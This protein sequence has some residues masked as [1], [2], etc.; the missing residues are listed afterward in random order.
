MM[1]KLVVKGLKSFNDKGRQFK[2]CI[3]RPITSNLL[4]WLKGIYL[5][6]NKQS[7][8]DPRPGNCLSFSEKS[9]QKIV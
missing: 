8:F 9:L 3:A 1:G 2:N 7:Y 4:G 5:F 6:F